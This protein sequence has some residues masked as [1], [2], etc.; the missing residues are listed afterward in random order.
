MGHPEIQEAKE[1][2][3]TAT[4]C[5]LLVRRC[6]ETAAT[7]NPPPYPQALR[8]S[9][10]SGSSRPCRLNS[11]STRMQMALRR[12]MT[13]MGAGSG[14]QCIALVRRMSRM[15]AESLALHGATNQDQ[16]QVWSLSVKVRTSSHFLVGFV[17]A[18][19][20]GAFPKHP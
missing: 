14:E 5:A 11:L 1:T 3:E 16:M 8:L 17:L 20:K 13:A 18:R 9:I 12:V 19:Q 4:P 15:E 10:T 7:E 2:E 6:C